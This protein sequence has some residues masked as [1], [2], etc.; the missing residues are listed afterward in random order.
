MS[1]QSVPMIA[2]PMQPAQIMMVLLLALATSDSVAIAPIVSTSMSAQQTP[3]T[4]L[5]MPLVQIVTDPSY[6]L[7]TQDTQETALSA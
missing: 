3:I 6:A 4:V 2:I 5:S 1:V 7:V